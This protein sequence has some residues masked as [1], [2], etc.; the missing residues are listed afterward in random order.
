MQKLPERKS[1]GLLSKSFCRF[2]AVCKPPCE[3]IAHIFCWKTWLIV[4]VFFFGRNLRL[5]GGEGRVPSVWAFSR[6]RPLSR[7]PPPGQGSYRQTS[8]MD[9][10]GHGPSHLKFTH[11]KSKSDRR[12]SA[13]DM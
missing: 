1:T 7:L 9:Y 13:S 6:R 10:D 12:P 4:E 11:C 5:T 2:E 8:Q 3:A